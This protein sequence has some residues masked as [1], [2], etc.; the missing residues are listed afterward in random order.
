M[1]ID[2]VNKEPCPHEVDPEIEALS[3]L[4]AWHHLIW[5]LPYLINA[6]QREEAMRE[7]VAWYERVVVRRDE[8][9]DPPIVAL[10]AMTDEL[11]LASAP[12][13]VLV[14]VAR[15]RWAVR[16]AE[17]LVQWRRCL[18]TTEAGSSPLAQATGRLEDAFEEGQSH[19]EGSV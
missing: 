3:K 7:L 19:I 15:A 5:A 12:H 17:E 14:E 6:D 18:R 13:D 2:E 11:T 10:D 9:G 4:R 16:A 8:A 1:S